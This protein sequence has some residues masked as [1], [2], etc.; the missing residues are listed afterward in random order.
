LQRTQKLNQKQN[1][2]ASQFH[3]RWDTAGIMPGIPRHLTL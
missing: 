1:A 3:P 2:G